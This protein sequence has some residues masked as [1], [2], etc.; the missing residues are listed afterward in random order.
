[1]TRMIKPITSII[2]P[3][4]NCGEW[5]PRAV[6]SA[7]KLSGG[8]VE[9]IVV[10]DGSTDNT[11]KI[12]EQLHVKYKT[13][14]VVHRENG[15]LSA[16]R[17]T[18]LEHATGQYIIFLDADDEIQ[19][20]FNLES[21][22]GNAEVFRIAVAPVID[23]IEEKTRTAKITFQCGRDFLLAC[24]KANSVQTEAWAYIY[25]HDFLNKNSLRFVPGLIHEDALFTAQALILAKTVHFN[26]DVKYRFHHRVGSITR[27]PA[28]E[29]LLERLRSL[30]KINREL[31]RIL[32]R[33]PNPGLT[34]WIILHLEYSLGIA[35]DLSLRSGFLLQLIMEARSL[36]LIPRWDETRGRRAQLSRI[37][38]VI[39]LLVRGT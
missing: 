24:I 14:K 25:K 8:T 23:G 12:C 28:P 7:F 6:D 1:M 27:A 17:N 10:N 19:G 35:K 31:L 29:R 22:P 5:L 16:A 4:Y 26:G 39:G 3:S 18:G 38:Q 11:P 13:L 30:N 33:I 2:I 15:G 9:V 32:R 34:L 37:R 36:L 20:S 21:L